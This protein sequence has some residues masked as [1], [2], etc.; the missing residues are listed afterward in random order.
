MSILMQLREVIVAKKLPSPLSM[1]C[2]LFK[3]DFLQ[4]LAGYPF[5]PKALLLYLT[6]RCNARCVMCGIWKTHEFSDAETELSL[7]ELDQILS[8]PLFSGIEYLNINGGEPTL[9][10][11]IVDVVQLILAKLPRLKHLSMNSNGLLTNKLTSTVAQILAMCRSKDIPFSLIISFHGVGELSDEIFGV[12]GAYQRLEKTLAELQA[13]DGCHHR[14]LSLNCIITNVNASSLREVWTW[15]KQR[16]L[17]VNFVLGEVRERFFNQDMAARTVLSGDRKKEATTFLKD[18]AQQKSLLNP[19][20]FRY[21]RLARMLERGEKRQMS[22]H[23]AM[24]GV[25]L[26]SHG[27]LYYC[28]QSKSIGNCKVRSASQIYFDQENLAYRECRLMRDKCLHCPPN[29]FDRLEFQK[30]LLRFFRFL[31]F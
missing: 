4:R 5:L 20:A 12:P 26:G 29:T 27:N 8:D 28:A 21:D 14:F 10:K 31:L 30:D 19:V 9:R 17:R 13:I 2:G 22:C 25:I 11:D 23:Y 24:G 16:D 15:C 3:H 6:Y 7:P 1:A 18:L